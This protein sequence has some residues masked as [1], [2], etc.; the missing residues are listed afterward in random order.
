MCCIY[1]TGY[2]DTFS[3]CLPILHLAAPL[4]F[5]SPPN[6]FFIFSLL[7][8]FVILFSFLFFLL[9]LS[10]SF[11]NRYFRFRWWGGFTSPPTHHWY[12]QRSTHQEACLQW[13]TILTMH[14]LPVPTRCTAIVF[15]LKQPTPDPARKVHNNWVITYILGF[16]AEVNV[17][18]L[19][20][21]KDCVC[22]IIAHMRLTFSYCSNQAT[23]FGY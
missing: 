8:F 23:T 9:L 20:F 21:C 2:C 14:K 22:D 15:L 11:P 19:P 4:P 12:R 7:L 17:H 6:L 1:Q 10:F 16:P 5:T 3:I 13:F 18:Q